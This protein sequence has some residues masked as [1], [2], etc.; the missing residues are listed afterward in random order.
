MLGVTSLLSWKLTE[1]Q[2]TKILQA[3][4]VTGLLA[5]V[6]VLVGMLLTG[7]PTYRSRSAT[8]S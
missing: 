5:A 1:Q 2:T 6:A 3:G 7:S 4:T 8:T